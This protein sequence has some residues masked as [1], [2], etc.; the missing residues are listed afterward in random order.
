MSL[1]CGIVGLPNVGKSTLFNALLG[2]AAAEAANYP[3]CTIEPNKGI[4]SV[5]DN[6]LTELTKINGSKAIIPTQ[7][8]F[9]DI[10]GLVKGAHKGEGLGN[11]FLAN[12][13]EVDA[14]IHVLRCFENSDIIHVEGKVDPIRDLEI[15]NL[16]LAISDLKSLETRITNLNKKA[17]AND[18]DAK[19]EIA[20]ANLALECLEKEL[21]LSSLN[22][23]EEQQLI[24][25]QFNL[26]TA[27]PVI[28]VCNVAESDLKDGN[29][30]SKEVEAFLIKKGYHPPLIISSKIEEDIAALSTEA[31]KQEYLD[32]MG[33][34]ESG[35]NK[36]IKESYNI[37]NLITY[38]TS[39]VK[40]TRAWTITN[41]CNA[42][43]AAGVIH[44]DFPKGFICAEVTSYSDFIT[45]KT[46]VKQLGKTRQ[47]GKDYI[48]KDGDII[49]FRFN[50]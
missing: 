14:I 19:A 38:F 28:Y 9:V 1:K 42:K 3:F 25:K 45:Y 34:K 32:L 15:I 21:P 18:K 26:L 20:V 31:E 24:L 41:G 47:E 10:A 5:P 23:T 2:R 4:V 27:K 43:N 22:L 8:E 40:E 36:I 37:L 29:N 16:E 46:E 6:R 12:I 39:G 17:K 49:I 50:V 13:R 7:L 35:L 33:L 30:Y 44:S 48:V 11:Q